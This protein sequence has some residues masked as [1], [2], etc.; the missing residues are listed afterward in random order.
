MGRIGHAKL[1]AKRDRWNASVMVGDVL[2][3]LR[4][5]DGAQ[6]IADETVEF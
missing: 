3:H 6:Q 1:A 5:G 2:N 4:I